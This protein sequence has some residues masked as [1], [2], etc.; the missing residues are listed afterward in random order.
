MKLSTLI[1]TATTAAVLGTAGVSIAGATSSTNA[2]KTATV[3]A[4]GT[5]AASKDANR[6][7]RRAHRGQRVRKALDVVAQTI[8]IDRADLVKELRDGKS[9][10]DVAAAHNVDR[11]AVVDALVQAAKDKI[12]AAVAA[13][14]LPADKAAT[15]EAKLGDRAG[16][17]VD[18]K[19]LG[20]ALEARRHMIRKNGRAA[21]KLAADTIGISPADLV[22]QLKDGKTIADVAT[23]HHVDPQAV[24]TALVTAAST[25][26]DAALGAGKITAE[27]AATLKEHAPQRIAH[28]VNEGRLRRAQTNG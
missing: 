26:I 3:A 20:K 7:A 10:A 1:A 11:Q 12:D 24:I 8:G 2:P 15:I 6:A 28:L 22:K 5:S 27:R 14:K 18:A 25:K 23:A 19:H 13:G 21:V 16:K 4:D 9:I 17:L